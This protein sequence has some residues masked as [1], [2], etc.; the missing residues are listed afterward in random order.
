MARNPRLS[1]ELA[2]QI[3]QAAKRMDVA[4]TPADAATAR[5][6]LLELH[7][8][9]T[10]LREPIRALLEVATAGGDEDTRGVPANADRAMHRLARD[11]L[12]A[13]RED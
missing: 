2:Q 10:N 4:D 1:K 12:H 3:R 7:T 6:I 5:E 9:I 13:A 11:I 8:A